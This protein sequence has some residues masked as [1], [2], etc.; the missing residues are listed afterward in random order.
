MI[1]HTVRGL[2]YGEKKKRRF[3]MESYGVCKFIHLL[4]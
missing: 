1:N 2:Y 3:M 4:Y